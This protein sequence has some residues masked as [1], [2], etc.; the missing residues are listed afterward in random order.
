MTFY[1]VVLVCFVELCVAFLPAVALCVVHVWSVACLFSKRQKKKRIRN[2]TGL[3][4]LYKLYR[5]NKWNQC[6]FFFHGK[7][8]KKDA[9]G[10]KKQ[11]T[12]L[13]S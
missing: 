5:M 2:Q 1:K 12:W 7:Q 13:H 3:L 9:K 4:Q 11:E 6:F 10:V 8:E